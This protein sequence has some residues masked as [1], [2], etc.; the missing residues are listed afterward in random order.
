MVPKL[1]DRREWTVEEL[2]DLPSDLRYELIDGRLTLPSPTPAHQYVTRF[3]SNAVE[4][5]CPPEYFVSI[6]QSLRIDERNEPRPDVVAIR[7]EQLD[8]TPVPVE[9]AILAIEV[10]SPHSEFR[11]LYDKAKAYAAAGIGT[12]WVVQQV[13]DA[14]SL[15]EMVLNREAGLYKTGRWTTEVF[16]V[17]QPWE[18]TVDLPALSTRLAALR[19]RA[20][21][22]E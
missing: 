2:A 20:K 15:T 19:E 7:V 1:P 12:Y 18:I 16:S 17:S 3:L 14:L 6:D 21:P 11:D 13:P 8:R 4:A 9:D 5:N 22:A 10:V